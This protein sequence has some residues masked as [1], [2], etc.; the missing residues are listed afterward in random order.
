MGFPKESFTWQ[1]SKSYIMPQPTDLFCHTIF[2]AKF[3]MLTSSSLQFLAN[4][5]GGYTPH[6]IFG[7]IFGRQIYLGTVLHER[8]MIRSSF[9]GRESWAWGS[10]WGLP[11]GMFVGLVVKGNY[12]WCLVLFVMFM[13][14]GGAEVVDA[15]NSSF[16]GGNA[17]HKRGIISAVSPVLYLLR[18]AR[19]KVQVKVS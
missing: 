4:I 1:H 10:K 5:E 8:W 15:L 6:L 7:I 17:S 12:V 13:G 19:P 11:W 9:H 16:G 2:F 18:L 3:S 14:F